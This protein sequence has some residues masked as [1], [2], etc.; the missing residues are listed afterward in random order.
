M[1]KEN[2]NPNFK[3]DSDFFKANVV[4]STIIAYN[5]ADHKNRLDQI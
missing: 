5:M 4:D 3:I 2:H 1:I